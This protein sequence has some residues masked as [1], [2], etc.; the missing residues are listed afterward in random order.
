MFSLCVIVFRFVLST[1]NAKNK[2]QN[3]TLRP[4][5]GFNNSTS[6]PSADGHCVRRY[7]ARH[8]HRCNK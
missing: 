3:P 6:T 5:T 7:A 8:F 1:D 4:N 2:M